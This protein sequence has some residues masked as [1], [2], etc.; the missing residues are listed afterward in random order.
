MNKYQGVQKASRSS[1]VSGEYCFLA[2]SLSLA[3]Q[4]LLVKQS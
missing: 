2:V 3:G 1:Q 4:A